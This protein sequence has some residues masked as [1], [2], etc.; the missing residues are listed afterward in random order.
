MAYNIALNCLTGICEAPPPDESCFTGG[1]NARYFQVCLD[2]DG[3][4]E[5]FESPEGYQQLAAGLDREGYALCSGPGGAVTHGF[6]AG[7][8]E[9][10]FDLPTIVQP[11]G[12]GTLPLTVVRIRATAY[13]SSPRATVSTPRSRTSRSS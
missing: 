10:G 7:L 6:D 11:G 9:A 4:L 5:E 3:T 2:Q 12:A 1:S 13:S 8:D